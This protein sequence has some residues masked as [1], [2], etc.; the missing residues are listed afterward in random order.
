MFNVLEKTRDFYSFVDVIYAF[1]KGELY[2]QLERSARNFEVNG[3]LSLKVLYQKI[4]LTF[5]TRR[6]FLRPVLSK[7][8]FF[9]I[10]PACKF[11]L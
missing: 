6:L 10:K 7:T 1:L 8:Y 3:M 9:L 4:V 11:S 2:V 5:E